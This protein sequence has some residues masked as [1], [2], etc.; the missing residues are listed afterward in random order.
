MFGVNIQRHNNNVGLQPE[1]ANLYQQY[2]NQEWK[3]EEELKECCGRIF[4]DSIPE[5][6]P[7]LEKIVDF[8]EI[9]VILVSNYTCMMGLPFIT[10]ATGFKGIVYATEPTLQIGRFFMEEL[11]QYIEQTPRTTLAK[12]WKEMLHI[13]PSP[14]AD[15]VKPNLGGINYYFLQDIYRALTVT[16][17]S[18]GYCLGSSNWLI[19]CEHEKVAYVSGSSTLITHPRPMK[20]TTL[21]HS[22]VLILTGLT[23][24][25]TVNFDTMLG[26]LC[27]AVAM[28]L[29]SSGCVLIPCYPSGVVND[30]FE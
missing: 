6:S 12:Y 4:V 9:D 24:T 2:H 15:A 22:D 27:M 3:I 30:L 20:Q 13:L 5:F 25:P 11:V 14:L 8:S 7:P 23:Q 18:S 1:H 16:S 19:S 21:K 10:E 29:R 17:I 26:E 28:T